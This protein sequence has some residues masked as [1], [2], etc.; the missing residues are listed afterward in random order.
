MGLKIK[1]IAQRA[2]VSLATVSRV[3][4][5]SGYVKEE[6]RDLV[7]KVMREMNY[8]NE[9]LVKK[10]S[11]LKSNIIGVVIPDIANPFFAE[12]LKGINKVADIE[13]LN[14]ILC[15]TDENIDKEIRYLEMLKEHNI[16]GLIITPTTDQNEFNRKYLEQLESMGVPIVLLDRDIKFSHFDAVFLD[17]IKGA[18][19]AVEALIRE[20]HKKIAIIAGPTTSKP[21]RDRVNGYLKALG[22]NN[23]PVDEKYIFYGDFR[24]E[25][26]YSLTKRILNMKEPPSAIFVSNNMM[27]K[28][29]IKALFEAKIRIPEDIGIIGF[30][31]VDLITLMDLN[32]S[33]VSRPTTQMGEVAMGILM[34]RRKEGANSD[35]SVKEFLLPSSLLLRGSEKYIP[36]S[37]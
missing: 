19:E 35:G 5:D 27:T 15:D 22:M 6:T 21:G 11:K 18:Y 37:K 14:I 31:D 28:G 34:E 2:G 32:I 16:K 33:V 9:S 12:V 7:L 36:K 13:K 23:I 29:C 3:I 4:N 25:S 26:G 30:D 24:F 1:D 10:P 17:S 8:S 20:G